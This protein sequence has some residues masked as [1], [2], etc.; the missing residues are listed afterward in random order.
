MIVANWKESI[1]RM[2]QS[3]VAKSKEVAEVT[4][5]NMELSEAKREIFGR[6]NQKKK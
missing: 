2:A 5:L 4:R 6:Q 3:A 1:S